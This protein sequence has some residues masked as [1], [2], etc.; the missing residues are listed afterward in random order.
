[1]DWET[2]DF[3][4]NN[5]RIGHDT[6]IQVKAFVRAFVHFL[7]VGGNSMTMEDSV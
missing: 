6:E 7:F 4:R 2:F 1:M 3:Y 5:S